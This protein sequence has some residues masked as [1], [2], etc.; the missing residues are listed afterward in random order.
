MGVAPLGIVASAHRV[1]PPPAGYIDIPTTNATNNVQAAATDNPAI[2]DLI[3]T[4][5]LRLYTVPGTANRSI[6]ERWLTQSIGANRYL[7]R[8]VTGGF[9]TLLYSQAG[10]QTRSSTKTWPFAA[11]QWGWLRINFDADDGAGNNVTKFE[12]SRDGVNW[13]VLDIVTVAGV[14]AIATGPAGY[15]SVGGR[16]G[17]NLGLDGAISDLK[18]E[19]DGVVDFEM[20]TAVDLAGVAVGAASFIAT[21]GETMTVNRTGSPALVLVPPP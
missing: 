17:S 3:V 8:F 7:T 15:T 9:P 5:R 2:T 1:P 4:A 16:I 21:S 10:N 13:T 18:V 6:V 11:G 14:A 20:H 19:L 12:T